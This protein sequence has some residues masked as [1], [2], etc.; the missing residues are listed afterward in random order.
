MKWT[1]GIV[2]GA[3]AA[4]SAVMVAGVQ[5]WE[6]KIEGQAQAAVVETAQPHQKQFSGVSSYTKHLPPFLV[7]AI[8][9]T[10]IKDKPIS[11]VLV[12][13]EEDEWASFVKKSLEDTYGQDVFHIQIYSYHDQTTKELVHSSFQQDLQKLN[14][15]LV[16]AEVPMLE[17][18]K[19]MP[20]DDAL[21]ELQEF[22]SQVKELKTAFI[23]QPSSPY[24]S[25]YESYEEAV[26]AVGGMAKENHVHYLNHAPLWPYEIS[27]Y[28]T[29]ESKLTKEG[30]RLWGEHLSSWFTGK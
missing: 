13:R 7:S 16:L 23:L 2:V 24:A 18:Q 21:P 8:E 30:K 29:K 20:I 19:E 10:F 28:V 4:C 14:P 1:S 3:F 26:A 25:Q 6:T 17:D 11:L 9:D 22:I 12:A 5:H 27:P 15:T